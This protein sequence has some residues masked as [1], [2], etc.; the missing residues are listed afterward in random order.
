MGVSARVARKLAKL[1]ICSSSFNVHEMVTA[2]QLR[3]LIMVLLYAYAN[4]CS[5]LRRQ[6][7]NVT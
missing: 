3:G 4:A 7:D 2:E 5:E 1:P 6:T